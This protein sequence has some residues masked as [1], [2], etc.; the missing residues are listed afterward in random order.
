MIKPRI[1]CY[2][3]GRTYRVFKNALGIRGLNLL[4]PLNELA[5]KSEAE[6]ISSPCPSARMKVEEF[7]LDFGNR[8]REKIRS[9]D[10]YSR[11]D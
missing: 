11:T 7:F 3:D 5:K 6:K 4:T 1:R 2:Q 9:N 8:W 10:Q